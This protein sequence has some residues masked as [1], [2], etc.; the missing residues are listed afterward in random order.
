[1]GEGAVKGW[2][3]EQVKSFLL[4]ELDVCTQVKMKVVH[5]QA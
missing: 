3:G 4:D 1:M 5:L 2:V